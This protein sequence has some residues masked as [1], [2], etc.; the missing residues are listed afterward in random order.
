MH[1][2]F[3]LKITFKTELGFV[4]VSKCPSYLNRSSQLVRACEH[5]DPSDTFQLL[6]VL[7]KRTN[8]NYKNY[9]CARCNRATNVTFWQA[10]HGCDNVL[11]QGNFNLTSFRKRFCNERKFSWTFS[12]PGN[13]IAHYCTVKKHEGWCKEASSNKQVN[14]EMVKNLCEAYYLPVCQQQSHFPSHGTLYNNPHCLLCGVRFFIDSHCFAC[15]TVNMVKA[16][17][18]LQIVFDFSSTSEIKVTAGGRTI[19]VIPERCSERQVYDPFSRFCRDLAPVPEPMMEI[20]RLLNNSSL[21]TTIFNSTSNTINS[22]SISNTTLTNS[23][24]NVTFTQNC[25]LVQFTNEEFKLFPNRSVFIKP[26]NRVYPKTLYNLYK[27]GIV[28]CTN[29]LR[30]FTKIVAESKESVSSLVLRVITYVGG[31]LSILTLIILIAVYVRI[32][33]IKKL[34]GKIVMSLSCALLVFQGG[35][36]LNGLT[37]IPALC[38]VVAVVLHYF[39]LASFTW[40]NVLVANVV[41]TIISTSK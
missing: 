14:W 31:A 23:T 21:P 17:Q 9:F 10:R 2:C 25:T 4:V 32:K 28:L 6:P 29:F 35:F 27:N 11:V 38:S 8:I 34:P 16:P 37:R 3:D 40:M 19:V 24:S 13:A 15:P 33:E 5:P 26:H 18:G 30:N 7:D 41:Y 36:F 12:P 39:L 1:S 22:N 20:K